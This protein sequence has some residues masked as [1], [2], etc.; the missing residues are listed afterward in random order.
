MQTESQETDKDQRGL[1]LTCLSQ[2]LRSWPG[3][4]VRMPRRLTRWDLTRKLCLWESLNNGK[5]MISQ[6][7]FSICIKVAYSGPGLG[8]GNTRG[9]VRDSPSRRES[10]SAAC[11]AGS[12]H[13]GRL[14]EL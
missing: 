7:T 13:C 5:C 14:K 12:S 6:L 2:L 9:A 8:P 1:T 3:S 4:I 10:Q 11:S